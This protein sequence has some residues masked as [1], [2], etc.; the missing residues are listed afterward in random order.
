MPE[1]HAYRLSA[2]LWKRAL[3]L[4]PLPAYITWNTQ[5]G[6]MELCPDS[7][8]QSIC[9]LGWLTGTYICLWRRESRRRGAISVSSHVSGGKQWIKV[10]SV[11][12]WAATAAFIPNALYLKV[13]SS[14]EKCNVFLKHLLEW[15]TYRYIFFPSNESRIRWKCSN[16]EL[17]FSEPLFLLSFYNL[18]GEGEEITASEQTVNILL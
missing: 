11:I 1:A 14:C 9:S 16:L 18:S 5:K 6:W 3:C 4:D 12:F 17:H 7:G 10:R 8:H 15:S 13:R 2:T